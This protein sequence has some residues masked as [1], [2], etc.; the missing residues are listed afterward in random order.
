MKQAKYQC[1]KNPKVIVYHSVQVAEKQRLGGLMVTSTTVSA[2]LA[3]TLKNVQSSSDKLLRREGLYSGAGSLYKL[4]KCKSSSH[5]DSETCRVSPPG[6]RVADVKPDTM[7][8]YFQSFKG[9]NPI[10]IVL[11]HLTHSQAAVAR[12]RWAL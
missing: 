11:F 4:Y 10:E 12:A 5:V 3:P 8:F 7:F 2:G 6:V 1:V 9:G